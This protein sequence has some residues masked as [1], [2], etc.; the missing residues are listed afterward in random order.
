MGYD[1]SVVEES[2]RRFFS[3]LAARVYY[4]A[5]RTYLVIYDYPLDEYVE[6]VDF[7]CQTRQG[8]ARGIVEVHVI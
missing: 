1:P 7:L 6:L 4:G 5:D 3:P 2:D 8:V